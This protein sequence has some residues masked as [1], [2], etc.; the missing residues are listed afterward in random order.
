MKAKKLSDSMK[1]ELV[2]FAYRLV[3]VAG[4][5]LDGTIRYHCALNVKSLLALEAR[6]LVEVSTSV[7]RDQ[8]SSRLYGWRTYLSTDYHVNLTE[9]G[10]ELV[11]TMNYTKGDQ[12]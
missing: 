3:K 5:E 8:R 1:R 9:A 2:H 12:S 11:S 7:S 10:R 4:R 6:G